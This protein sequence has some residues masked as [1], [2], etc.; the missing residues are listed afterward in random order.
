M[1]SDKSDNER[2]YLDGHDF[3]RAHLRD[4]LSGLA[5]RAEK[6]EATMVEYNDIKNWDYAGLIQAFNAEDGR[7]LGMRVSDGGEL[8][9]AIE[10]AL[11][12]HDG[13]TLIEC[14]IDRD[15]CSPELIS[16]GRLVARANARPPIPQ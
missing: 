1:S 7:G 4:F 11:A 8:A 6:R 14:I 3:A 12:N 16:W 10:A 2:V 9:S 5:R 13:P 15:D